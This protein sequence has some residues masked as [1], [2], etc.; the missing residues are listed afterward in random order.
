MHSSVSLCEV[1]RGTG[2]LTARLLR[3][4]RGVAPGGWA[5]FTVR[6]VAT[7]CGGISGGFSL[8]GN[9]VSASERD[10]GVNAT[11]HGDA[12]SRFANIGALSVS[13]RLS[14]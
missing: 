14:H 11:R 10:P 1:R 6:P 2:V 7:H 5:A 9:S 8:C 12:N 13:R 4:T 3:S